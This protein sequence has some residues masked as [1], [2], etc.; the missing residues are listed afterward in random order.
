MNLTETV[1]NHLLNHEYVT[2]TLNTAFPSHYTHH[3][4]IE[5]HTTEVAEKH[6]KAFRHLK[7]S[8]DFGKAKIILTNYNTWS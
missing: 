7:T 5:D 8:S 6:I 1:L 3:D 2:T 4:H